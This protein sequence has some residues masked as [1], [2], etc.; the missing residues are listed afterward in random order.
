MSKG[1]GDGAGEVLTGSPT[2]HGGCV[3]SA[4]SCHEGGATSSGRMASDPELTEPLT[5][6][7]TH[8]QLPTKLQ[9]SKPSFHL[10]PPRILFYLI[11]RCVSTTVHWGFPSEAGVTSSPF[12]ND[13]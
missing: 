6:S 12:T 8:Q 10:G 3:S 2:S 1:A 5:L 11:R 9:P 13:D 7:Y 4:A